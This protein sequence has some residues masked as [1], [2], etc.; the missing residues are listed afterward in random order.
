ML[1]INIKFISKFAIRPTFRLQLAHFLYQ[2]RR[3]NSGKVLL[4]AFENVL[5]KHIWNSSQLF[6]CRITPAQM[7]ML[8]VM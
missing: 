6:Q 5:L 3:Q 4:A 2:L 1:W 8:V 7:K